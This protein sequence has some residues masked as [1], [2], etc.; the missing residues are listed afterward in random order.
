MGALQ[1]M[2]VVTFDQGRGAQREMRA[3]FA[4]PR[5]RD[6]AL[7]DTHAALL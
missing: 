7:G 5:F 2:T 4:F 3:A 1:L 6:F